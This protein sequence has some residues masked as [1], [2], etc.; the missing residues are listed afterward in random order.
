M[1]CILVPKRCSHLK[2]KLHIF[3]CTNKHFLFEF[4][5]FKRRNTVFNLQ[6]FEIIWNLLFCRLEASLWRAT[7]MAFKFL[8]RRWR[9]TDQSETSKHPAGTNDRAGCGLPILYWPIRDKLTSNHSRDFWQGADKLITG[10]CCWLLV[11]YIYTLISSTNNP[12][13]G[14]ANYPTRLHRLII[15]IIMHA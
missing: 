7:W 15:K 12:T 3:M 6:K 10:T 8:E 5:R 2:Y 14:L 13:N 9:T 1:L 4:Q 11:C